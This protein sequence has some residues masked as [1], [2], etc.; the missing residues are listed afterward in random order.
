MK[1]NYILI[2][3]MIAAFSVVALGLFSFLPQMYGPF[4][5]CLASFALNGQCPSVNNPLTVGNFHISGFKV[6][7][8]VSIFSLLTTIIFAIL[9][10]VILGKTPDVFPNAL[11]LERVKKPLPRLKDR[12]RRWF[13]LHQKR[14][15]RLD[16]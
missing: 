9:S 6:L 13:N 2:G 4:H 10:F 7:S 5:F 14:D 15:P 12:M 11:S 16:F 1:P 8:T 3:L